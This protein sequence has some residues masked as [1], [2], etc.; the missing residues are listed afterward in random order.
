MP[1]CEFIR[2]A[3]H[4]LQIIRLFWNWS[5]LQKLKIFT[6]IYFCS[7]ISKKSL[8]LWNQNWVLV[9]QT[10]IRNGVII[11]QID[12]YPRRHHHS[13]VRAPSWENYLS[14]FWRESLRFSK[15]KSSESDVG[16]KS[17]LVHTGLNALHNVYLKICKQKT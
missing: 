5:L 16:N 15:E 10:S 8:L 6:V 7:L 17:A 4:C 2:Q 14:F 1:I 12:T 13:S 3:G 11:K 9:C